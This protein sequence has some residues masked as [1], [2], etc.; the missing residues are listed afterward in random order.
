MDKDHPSQ[1]PDTRS[2]V[3]IFVLLMVLLGATVAAAFVDF[4]HWLP[5]HF[6]NLGIAGLI[7]TTKGVLILLYFMHIKSGPRRAIMFAAAGFL[8]LAILS[9]LILADYLTRNTPN[10]PSPKGEP[11]M[12]QVRVN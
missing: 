10:Y 4:H 6:W 1:H 5:G 7:A 11:R 2:Y 8:W 9:V 3:I 12:L